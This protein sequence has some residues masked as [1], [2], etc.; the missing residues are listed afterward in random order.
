MSRS[1]TSNTPQGVGIQLVEQRWVER[2]QAEAFAYTADFANIELWDPGVASSEKTTDGPVGV[3]T[4]YR[5]E[6]LFGKAKTPMTYEITE[7]EEPNRVVLVGH[8]EK[9]HAVDEIRFA[10][11]DNMTVIDYTADLTFD[12][13]IRFLIPFMGRA[14]KGVGTRALDGLARALDE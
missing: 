14:F 1:T 3:G 6:V 11:A 4:K 10:T 5:V 7:F 2:S 9:I 13:F 8:G 12:N